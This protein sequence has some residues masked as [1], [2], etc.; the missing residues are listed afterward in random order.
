MRGR[1]A[2]VFEGGTRVPFFVHW[3]AGFKGDRDIEQIAAHIDIAPTLVNAC[4]GAMPKDRTID[5]KNLL[6][7]WKGQK[8]D[9][10]DRSL[11]FQW[12]RGDVPEPYRACAVRTQQWRLVQPI[13]VA[14]KSKFDKTKF[15]LFDIGKDPFEMNDVAAEHP[16][17]VK[18]LKKEYEAW[19]RDV[20][21]TRKFAPPLIVVG[22]EKENPTIL[23]RQDWRGPD[24]GW[25]PKSIG[26]W[27]IQVERG[28]DY[29]IEVT[30][31]SPAAKDAVVNLRVG[32]TLV[33][34]KLDVNQKVV[35][36][37]GIR[38]PAGAVRLEAFA[39]QGDARTGAR[40]V[41][42]RKIK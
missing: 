20:E 28:G 5:G 1:K 10:L 14:E 34:Q 31:Q 26:S 11:F 30:L 4:G 24:A 12:H 33:E 40:F 6:P 27:A 2:S 25:T 15:M 21:S 38:L 17:V 19:F 18:N 13:G 29:D 3:P 16:D 23:T 35:L 41:E 8:I 36:L 9:W 39:V 32:T 22:S 7:L 37:D 42:L